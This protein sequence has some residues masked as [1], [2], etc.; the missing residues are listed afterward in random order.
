MKKIIT[1]FLLSY[2]I[3]F[4][5]TQQEKDLLLKVIQG[6]YKD[7]IYSVAVKKSQEYLKKTDKNDIYRRQVYKIL[8]YSLY[9]TKNKKDFWKLIESS[10]IPEEDRDIY[11]QLGL[12]LFK[13]EPDKLEYFYK[14]LEKKLADDKKEKIAKFLAVEYVKRKKWEKVLSL[15]S[16][17]SVN[18]YKLI[19]LYR[20][21]RYE[22][23]I[24]KT[25]YL[26]IYPQEVK[27]TVLYFRGLAFSKLGKEKKA[28]STIEAI[29]F[30][31]PEMIK[32]L[33]NYYLKHKNYL[34]AQRYLK[35]LS[36][37]D[38][39][40]DYAYY[41]L[42][43]IEDILKRYKEALRYYKKASVY[44]TKYGKR[45]KERISILEKALPVYSVRLILLSSKKKAEGFIKEKKLKDCF[46]KKYKE[47][48][49]VYCGKFD[50]I[51]D[52]KK[53]QRELQEKGFD[54]W[55]QKI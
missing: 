35:I 49:G 40:K 55:I 29:T 18:L 21:R 20:L 34:Y 51:E 46:I 7:K 30:K 45:A 41:Y 14:K 5:L 28:V 48:Y 1:V 15:P 42:G 26:G 12:N 39:Y 32:F 47:Y 8:F 23:V 50:D 11:Y 17:K 6:A 3:S 19:A 24:K 43:V 33:A 52:A 9:Y 37:E 16:Y 36:L 31:T 22:D 13:D 44:K 25:E 10:D 27:D 54:T 38:E 4:G 2:T 53:F